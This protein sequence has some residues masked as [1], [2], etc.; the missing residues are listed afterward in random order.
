MTTDTMTDD[1]IAAHHAAVAERWDEINASDVIAHKVEIINRRAI[2]LKVAHDKHLN[3]LFKSP[4]STHAKIE[5]VWKAVDEVTAIAKPHAACR[6]GCGH[7][8]HQCVLLSEQE[9]E[10][11]GKRIGVKPKQ[12]VGITDRDDVKAGYDNPCPFLKNDECSI[13]EHRPLACRQQMNLDRDP[14]LCKPIGEMN[15][16][17]YLN[18]F[19]YT[20]ALA[21]ITTKRDE[22]TRRNPRTGLTEP[23]TKM[24]APNVGDIREFFPRG[25]R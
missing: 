10:L 19:E 21:M 17:P 25:R 22:I 1:E 18:L 7:C 11:I 9:A 24:T 23:G 6:R 2:P 16:V 5:G 3:A 8:C 20:T 13:Y 15:K 12:V 4:R 14:L